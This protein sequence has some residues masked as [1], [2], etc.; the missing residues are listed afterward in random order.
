MGVCGRLGAGAGIS[1]RGD[2]CL[3]EGP[4]RTSAAID[5]VD[6]HVGHTRCDARHC[7]APFP[8][9]YAA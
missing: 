6:D 2:D 1:L 9:V 7:R 3:V 5:G 8:A 4:K